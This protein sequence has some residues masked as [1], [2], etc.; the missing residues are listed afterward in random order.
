[1][2]AHLKS[3]GV[4]SKTDAGN[5]LWEEILDFAIK[6]KAMRTQ[7]QKFTDDK[8]KVNARRYLSILLID[9]AE[10]NS[11]TEKKANDQLQKAAKGQ[12]KDSGQATSTKR[13]NDG[14]DSKAPTA[15]YLEN[16]KRPA[17]TYLRSVC[18]RTKDD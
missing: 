17:S 13:K 15:Q 7:K 10:K 16:G 11:E 14:G 1:M 5:K 18:H 12:K 6:H 2:E 3:L 9:C 8:T 4:H